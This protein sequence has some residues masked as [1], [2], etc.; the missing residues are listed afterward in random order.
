MNNFQF[1]GENYLQIGGT[2]IGTRVAPS[3]TNLFMACLEDRL[4]ANCEYKLP[5]YLRYID[6]I[7]FIFPY[8]EA[9]LHKFMHYMNNSHP[10]IKFTEEHS[11]CEVV[12]LDTIVNKTWQQIVHRSVHKT[13]WYTQLSWIH[14]LTPKTHHPE[15]SIRTI[16]QTTSKLFLW[17]LQST[18]RQYGPTLYTHMD[19]HKTSSCKAET[20]P[21]Q[22]CTTIWYTNQWRKQHRN[23]AQL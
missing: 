4:L 12:F 20:K 3:C 2:A 8:S 1:N 15:W 13:N 22:S 11:R 21:L 14:V 7:F 5:L 17:R 6:D 9:D 16:P 19:T 10:T 23:H 18:R